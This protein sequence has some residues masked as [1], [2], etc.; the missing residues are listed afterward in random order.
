MVPFTMTKHKVRDLPFRVFAR[1]QEVRSVARAPRV[2]RTL[3]TA[4]F[5]G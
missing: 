4:F 2:K 3:A 5:A 1:A